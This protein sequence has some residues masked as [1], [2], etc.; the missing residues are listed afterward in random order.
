MNN[1]LRSTFLK[2]IIILTSG[3]ILAQLINLAATPVISRIYTPEIIGTYTYIISIAAI[4]MGVINGR[5]DVACV[6]DKEQNNIYPLI[7]LSLII[8]IIV[9]IIGTIVCTI[10][11]YTQQFPLQYAIYLFFILLSYAIIN[12]LTAYNNR[13]KEYKTISSVY[14]IRTASQNFGSIGLG[15]ISANPHSLLVPYAIGQYLGISKQAKPL[16]GKWYEILKVD[17]SEVKRVAIEHKNQPFFSMPAL[18]LNSLSYS[19]TTIFIEYLYTLETV[20]YYSISVRLLG[21]PLAIVG[22][23]VAK[24]FSER[25]ATEYSSYGTYTKSLTR[26]FLFLL[27]IAIPMVICMIYISEPL[28]VF[29]LGKDWATAGQYI[30]ILAP[31]FGIRLITSALSPALIIAKKQKAELVLQS[32]FIISGVTGFIMTKTYNYDIVFFLKYIMITYSISYLIYLYIIY[33]NRKV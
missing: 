18:L 15:A 24:V 17:F 22:G 25:A 3:S 33:K 7:K 26:T 11:F 19:L 21:L 6:V 8:G 9:T 10:Y 13:C 30:A 27:C 14:V 20:G 31:M 16:K 32:L 4:F 2:S 23:N 28:C 5:Y 1:I 12:V 29:F